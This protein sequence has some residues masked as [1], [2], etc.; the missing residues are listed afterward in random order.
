MSG[1]FYLRTDFDKQMSNELGLSDNFREE[2]QLESL[3]ILKG[4]KRKTMLDYYRTK[5]DM[6]IEAKEEK[7]S[8]RRKDPCN[9]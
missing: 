1:S 7:E 8:A 9:E 5:C 3:K 2:K 6:H 4:Q